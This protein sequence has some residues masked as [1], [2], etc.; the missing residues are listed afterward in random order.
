MPAPFIIDEWAIANYK[1]KAAPAETPD[2]VVSDELIVK[3][4]N[5]EFIPINKRLI[6]INFIKF[7]Y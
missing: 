4:G 2:N 5:Y 3:L 6:S 1:A 7:D